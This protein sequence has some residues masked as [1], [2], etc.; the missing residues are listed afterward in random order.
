M[1][2]KSFL[3]SAQTITCTED[4]AAPT[5]IWLAKL[6]TRNFEFV[7]VGSTKVDAYSALLRVVQRHSKQYDM[8]PAQ[9]DAMWFSHQEDLKFCALTLGDGTADYENWMN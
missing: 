8:T 4:A 2:F 6:T 1:T 9:W 5:D 3:T 7:A